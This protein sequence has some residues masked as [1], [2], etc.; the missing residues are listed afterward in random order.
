MQS[1]SGNLRDAFSLL[2]LQ[3]QG[4]DVRFSLFLSGCDCNKGHGQ[5][6]SIASPETIGDTDWRQAAT[7]MPTA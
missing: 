1:M 3:L 5:V 2:G 4:L 6:T 7:T